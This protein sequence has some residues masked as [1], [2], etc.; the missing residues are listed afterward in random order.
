[1]NK[2]MRTARLLKNYVLNRCMELCLNYIA[3]PFH[4]ESRVDEGNMVIEILCRRISGI[5]GIIHEVQ[6]R[7]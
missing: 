4:T 2:S 5:R 7:E 1:M 3:V 6:L